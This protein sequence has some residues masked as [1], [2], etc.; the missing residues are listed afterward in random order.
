MKNNVIIVTDLGGIFMMRKQW[1]KMIAVTVC[2][3]LSASLPGF[4]GQGNGLAA[5][6]QAAESTGFTEVKDAGVTSPD[7]EL[8][9]RILQNGKGR[10]YYTA[11]KQGSV[12]LEASALGIETASADFT[13]GAVLKNV[14][15]SEEKKQEYSLLNGKH[16]KVS[17]AYREMTFDLEKEGRICTVVVQAHND[18]LAY[19]YELHGEDGKEET[20]KGESSEF[21]LPEN[22]K[23]WAGSISNTYEYDYTSMT[24][25]Q[26]KAAS[27]KYSVPLLAS[28]GKAWVLLTEANVFNEE[29]PYCSSYLKTEAGSDSLSMTFGNKVGTVSMTYQN[30]KFHTP[31]RAAVI[32]DNLNTLMNSDLVTSL[33]PEAEEETYHYSEWVDSAKAAWSWWS[34]AG[35]DPI[36]YA[37]QED[38][39][40]FAAE[41]GWEMVC[42]DFGWCLWEDYQEKVAHLCEYAKERNVKIML[43]YGVN[44]TGHSGWK[45]ADGKA[46]YPTYSLKTTEDLQKQFSWAE[47][48]GVAAVK[49]DYYES[50]TQA[51]MEQMFQCA[52]I[53]A[54]HKLEVLFHG[55]TMP[56]GENR[57]FPN[58]LSYEAVF[59][60][61]Y[62]KFG[63]ASPTIETLLTY[64]YTR[65]VVGSMDFTPAALP[66]TAIPATAGFQLGETV[67]FESGIVTLASSIYAYEGNHA[68]PFLNELESK[69]EESRLLD[70][71][72]AEPGEYA[73]VAR[74][75][76]GKEK[77]LIGVMTKEKRT[78]N[79]SL[80]FLGEGEYKALVFSD[81][82]TG[83]ET[84]Y[85]ELTVTK[86]SVIKEELKENGGLGIVI[87][88]ESVE[89]PQLNV[90]YY[91]METAALSG[92]AV[93]SENSF[94]SG[95]KQVNLGYGSANQAAIEV[96]AEQ[97]GIYA[98]DVFYKAGSER[99][100]C[101]QVN[102]GEAVRTEAVSSGMNSIA[103]YTCYIKLSAGK[104]TIAFYN[105]N[106]N[107]VGL[108][109]VAVKKAPEESAQV[110]ESSE[111]TFEGKEG[112][113]YTY[114]SYLATEA[115]TNAVKEKGAVGWLGGNAGSYLEFTVQTDKKGGH[116]L[117]L[118]YMTGESRSVIVS[119][120]GGKGKSYFCAS[121]GGYALDSLDYEFFPASLKKGENSIR[122]T[123][124]SGYCPNIYSL[125][126]S[127]EQ[128][129]VPLE[130]GT[131]VVKN[132]LKFKLA[133]VNGKK[134]TAVVTGL[135]KNKASVS[136]PDTIVYDK[137]TFLV[138]EIAAGAFQGNKKLTSVTIGSNVEKIKKNAF[139][140][141]SSLKKVV[142][143]S[144]QVSIGKNAFQGISKKAVVKGVKL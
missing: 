96:T 84:E 53:A 83:S 88:R 56:G 123:N 137:K 89:I 20:V 116:M 126:V 92:E 22:A 51:T 46:A 121:T 131:V 58:I 120:N 98:M 27:S 93:V 52:K 41:N 74:K 82:E 54:E 127:E 80:D 129:E 100:F 76:V 112:I 114:S 10:Y 141:C 77:W 105:E 21:S 8:S 36:E 30:G 66:V 13:K 11:E 79:L 60:E 18:G 57:T 139:R 44:N 25:E 31:W 62:H 135:K 67:V 23:V 55:C 97:D 48:V 142:V 136:I 61:E 2:A 6:V 122:I 33:N 104:N 64:P 117:K 42:L 85:K 91:E 3:A 110:T 29:E 68:L 140:N 107:F 9:V 86:D 16:L 73:A 24:M 108:D 15:V 113:Q 65:N 38:Y 34:E 124:P 78:A 7:G 138:T 50:D 37:P 81:N 99:Q 32:A 101:Y 87:T 102:G 49:V 132:G 118:G 94:A 143:K 103:K 12:V 35:D 111:N 45:D 70:E 1:K 90:T 95:L 134:K 119:V 72:Q 26:L 125:G 43:W 144:K 28:T 47:S 17:D 106:A 130:S 39:I 115:K 133:K 75:A 69:W 14:Q 40:D 71:D 109:R 128:V 63:S 19:R 59:G 4:A 5:P